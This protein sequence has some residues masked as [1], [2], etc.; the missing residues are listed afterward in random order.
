MVI[1]I[2]IANLHRHT[3][4]KTFRN[5]FISPVALKSGSLATYT[6]PSGSGVAFIF[7]KR[8]S[9]LRPEIIRPYFFKRC[10]SD[11][12]YRHRLPHKNTPSAKVY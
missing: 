7:S 8:L 5:R 1:A 11:R 3:A 10:V 4:K 9:R 6:V 2:A 12:F